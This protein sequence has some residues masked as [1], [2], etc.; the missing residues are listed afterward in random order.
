MALT[1]EADD[2]TDASRR[3][4][5]MTLHASKGLEFDAVILVGMEERTFPHGRAYGSGSGGEGSDP[6]AMAEE[7][8][9]CYVGMTRA[10]RELVL[11]WAGAR[12]LMGRRQVREPSRFLREIP[13]ALIDPACRWQRRRSRVFE[14]GLGVGQGRRAAFEALAEEAEALAE[15]ALIPG[16]GEAVV[17]YTFDQRPPEERPSQ[18]ARRGARV[19]HRTFGEGRIVAVDGHGTRARLTVEFEG[20]GRKRIAARFVEIR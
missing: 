19:W 16:P 5:L 8:R 4:K 17:D 9:L 3:V 7:R 15:E 2:V 12:L 18:V 10:R 20:V 1:G 14:A 13:E 6:E 11:T